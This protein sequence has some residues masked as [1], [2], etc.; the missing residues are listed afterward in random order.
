MVAIIVNQIQLSN[1]ITNIRYMKDMQSTL[2]NSNSVG[3][4]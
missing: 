4:A 3:G 1:N 2:F